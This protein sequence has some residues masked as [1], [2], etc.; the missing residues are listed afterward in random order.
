MA[1]PTRLIRDDAYENIGASYQCLQVSTLD[2]ALRENGIADAAQRQS[3]CEAFLFAMGN[4][5]DQG[6]LKPGADADR[7]YPLLCF[8][9]R[10]LNT[11]TPI[12]ELGDVFAPSQFFAFHEYAMGNVASHFEGDPN[13]HVEC[14]DFEG[15]D[16]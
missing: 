8:S 5:H 6:W 16:A 2:T 11:D 10:F 3:I 9:K 14:G 4:L 7:M 12:G 15:E 1:E 13:A